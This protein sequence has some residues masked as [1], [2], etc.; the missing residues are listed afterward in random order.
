MKKKPYKFKLKDCVF[1]L[2][3]PGRCVIISR[4]AMFS[5]SGGTFNMYQLRGAHREFVLEDELI[6]LAEAKVLN[7][8][9]R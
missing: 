8:L 5:T 6:T 9:S 4:G 2:G 1:V 3:R 7:A